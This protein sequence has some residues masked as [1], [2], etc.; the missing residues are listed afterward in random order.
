MVAASESHD[1]AYADLPGVKLWYVDTGGDGVPIVLLHPNTGTVE[2]WEPQ[3]AGFAHAGYRVIAFDRRGWGK[4]TPDPSSGPQSG[5][6]AEDL[7]A[8]V[9]HLKL[10]KF[11]LL[12]VAGG[13]FSVLDYAAW[14]PER[15]RSLIVGGSTGAIEDK[16]I[17]EFIARIA[18]PEIRKQSA[19][20]REIGPS[21]RGANPEGT[22]RWIEIDERSR[23]PGVPF[24]P[25]LRTPNTLAKI[26]T[27]ATPTLLIAADADLLAPPALMRIWAA[28][29]RHHEWAV[30]HDAGHAM[31]WEQPGTFND[32]VLDFVRRY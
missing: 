2:I 29:L 6:I 10:E 8:L 15:L 31:A 9:E 26:A 32:K 22:Q 4:S 17:A 18:I 21:Y 11:H 19:H 23:Q 1:G 12:G 25:P 27:I 5:S 3:I 20:Y 24:Q 14:H 28:Y 7:H 30:I 16:K 13:G